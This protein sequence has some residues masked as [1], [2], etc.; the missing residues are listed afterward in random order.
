MHRKKLISPAEAAELF[1]VS[2]VTVR[3]WARK[4]EL[5]S[6]HTAGGHRRYLLE[7]IQS[8]ACRHGMTLFPHSR[9]RQ[10]ILVVENDW[11]FSAFIREALESIEPPVE[12]KFANE[13]FAAGRLLQSFQP[14]V[15]LLDL[16]LPGG[17]GMTICRHLRKDAAT[18]SIRVIAMTG[19]ASPENR[20]QILDAGAESCLAKP[21]TLHDL[22]VAITGG[23]AKTEPAFPR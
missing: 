22:T 20:L 7:D 3:N 5:I 23:G 1:G 10:R 21:F 4:G 16:M 15:V 17:D 2:P 11:Q 13:G 12:S 8:F 14:H 6:H 18:R 9:Q 19:Y